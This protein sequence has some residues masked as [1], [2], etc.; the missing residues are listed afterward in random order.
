V[1]TLYLDNNATTRVVDRVFATMR[2]YF[3]PHFAH[4]LKPASFSD[5]FR[6]MHKK[7]S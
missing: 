6:E 4:S 3:I 5:S 1:D 7:I 2:P